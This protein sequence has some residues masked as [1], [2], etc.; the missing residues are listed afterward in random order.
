M[1][2]GHF[3]EILNVFGQFYD[4]RAIFIA[5]NGKILKT[6][7]RHLVTLGPK[8]LPSVL[9][10]L[11]AI[12]LTI[13]VTS[14]KAKSFVFAFVLILTLS[15]SFD[16]SLA[17]KTPKVVTCVTEEEMNHNNVTFEERAVSALSRN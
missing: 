10:L 6:Q 8:T 2:F 15:Q 1:K 11:Q 3:G 7:S 17:A 16:I 13:K 12:F 9:P 4:L 14:K 5:L